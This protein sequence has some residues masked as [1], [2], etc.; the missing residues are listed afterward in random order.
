[1]PAINNPIVLAKIQ[2]FLAP[3]VAVHLHT[4]AEV[5]ST[6]VE[7]KTFARTH[8]TNEIQAFIAEQQSAG[9]GRSGRKFYSPE[10]TGIYMSL[11]L[12]MERIA[13][14]N[15]G[16]FTTGVAVSVVDALQ[17]SFPKTVFQLKW[18][19]DIYVNRQKCCGIL[20]EHFMVAGRDYVVLGIGI[21]VT[22]ANF[23]ADIARKAGG[24]QTEGGAV[25][26]NRIV[27]DVLSA[28][29]R[30]YPTYQNGGH[31]AKYRDLFMLKDCT[32]RLTVGNDSVVGTALTV[33]DDGGLVIETTDGTI[34]TFRSGEVTKVVF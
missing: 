4:Y 2:S 15:V 8:Q 17:V 9:Y 14:F 5:G 10:G 3:T 28:F 11:L 25:D 13:D 33:A 16:L 12:P 19:N 1:M 26:R 6:N 32:V 27:A 7:A 29:W 24:I 20:A 31:L 21:N 22:T 30:M 23:P 34:R 18:V